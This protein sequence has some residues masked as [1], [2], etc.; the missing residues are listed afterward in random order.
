MASGK[1]SPRQKMINMMYLVLTALLA[2]NVSSEILNAFKTVNRS[3]TKTNQVL[4]DKNNATYSAFTDALADVQTKQKALIWKPKADEIAKLS[5]EMYRFI[6]NYKTDIKKGAGLEIKKVDGV[7]EEHFKEDDL[8]V[9]TRIMIE[10]KKGKELYDKVKKYKEDILNVIRNSSDLDPKMKEMVMVDLKAFEKSLPINLDIPKKDKYGKAYSQDWNG[11]SSSNFYM[12][13]AIA[14][15]TILTKLQNDVKNSEAQLSDYCIAQLGKVKVVYDKFAAVAAANTTY[16]MPGE[17]IEVSAGVGAF[18]DQAKPVISIKGSNV[19]L[20][21]GMATYKFNAGGPGSYDIPVSIRF[22]TPTGEVKT[23]NRTIKYTVGQPSGAALMLDK[24]NVFY[25]GL[26][27]PVTVSSGTGDEKTSVIPSGGG[28]VTLSKVGPGKYIVRAKTV[29]EA[30]LT[31]NSGTQ[32]TPFKFRVKRVPDPIATIGG[33]LNNGKHPR[34]TF[35]V[36]QG[37]I[38]KLDNFDFEAR[39]EVISYEWT[40][41]PKGAG[42]LQSNTNNGPGFSPQLKN[43]I[44]SSKAKDAFSFEN[45]KVKGPDGQP[46]K[47]PGLTITLM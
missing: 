12:T 47:I 30:T 45:I 10:Q 8:D 40:Y 22:T 9:S 16:C 42:D 29:G 20:T 46:R 39:F 28:G 7:D 32:Q 19:P 14:S 37:M 27:N 43:L 17:A 44:S 18:N 2:M 6:E 4:T 26:D 25:I 31:V 13:P 34:G 11:W 3:I 23:E 5:N 21:D 1:I 36:Q 15:L 38:A 35:V 33:S 24:M 41:M